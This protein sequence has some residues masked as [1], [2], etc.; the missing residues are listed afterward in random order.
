VHLVAL[1]ERAERGDLG[2]VRDNVEPE[3]DRAVGL[4]LD[5]VDR[6]RDAVDG[7]RAL[8]RNERRDLARRGNCQARGITFGASLDNSADRVDMARDDVPS[9]LVADPQRGLE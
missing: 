6:E 5:R 7:Y 1:G 9:E 2:R 4:V 3:T 8:L